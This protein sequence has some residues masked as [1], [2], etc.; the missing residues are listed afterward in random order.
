MMY[1]I[2]AE[3]FFGIYG[4][5]ETSLCI[6]LQLLRALSAVRAKEIDAAHA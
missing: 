6:A 3:K 4:T 5:R 1:K 2:C